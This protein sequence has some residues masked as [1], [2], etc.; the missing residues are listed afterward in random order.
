M[1][2]FRKTLISQLQ[3]ILLTARGTDRRM[4]GMMDGPYFKVP[5]RPRLGVQRD[6]CGM[7]LVSPSASKTCKLVSDFKACNCPRLSCS[8]PTKLSC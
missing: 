8:I 6:S 5:F 1:L 3:E 4:D 2:S 7:V